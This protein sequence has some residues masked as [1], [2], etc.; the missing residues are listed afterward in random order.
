MDGLFKDLPYAA[1]FRHEKPFVS[2]VSRDHNQVR[3]EE[4]V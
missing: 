1:L 3:P 4:C 2:V